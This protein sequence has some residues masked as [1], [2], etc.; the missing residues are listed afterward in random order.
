[1]TNFPSTGTMFGIQFDAA[2]IYLVGTPT[3]QFHLA[4]EE[5]ISFLK[6]SPPYSS[7][8]SPVKF[9]QQL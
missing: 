1:M 2:G 9:F 5:L 7:T 8:G 4:F 3:A 6:A